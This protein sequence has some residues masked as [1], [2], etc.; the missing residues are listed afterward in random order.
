RESLR[1]PLDFLHHSVIP[2]GDPNDPSGI[3]QTFKALLPEFYKIQ[4]SEA[5]PKV[6][7]SPDPVADL[8]K[9]F[10]D[11]HIE[12]DYKENQF[13]QSLREAFIHNREKIFL[14]GVMPECHP[15]IKH[16]RWIATKG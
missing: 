9:A 15:L 7:L 14:V 6:K 8:L 1:P 2:N 4:I 5:A 10:H 16:P 3:A 13:L 11:V 12:A